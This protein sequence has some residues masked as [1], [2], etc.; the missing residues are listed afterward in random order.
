MKWLLAVLAVASSLH[1]AERLEYSQAAMGT[2]FR[3]SLYAEDKAKADRVVGQ[4]WKRV[5]ELEQMA[6]DYLPESELSRLC[7]SSEPM[8]VSADL[9]ALLTQ[10]QAFAQQTE[11]A[12]DI[13]TGHLTQLWRRAKRKSALPAPA[14]LDEALSL[15]GWQRLQLGPRVSLLPRTQLDL[16]GIA[17]GYA[18]DVALQLLKDAGFPCAVVAASGDLA[19]GTAPPGQKGW[20]VKL[21]TFETETSLTTLQLQHCGVST[22]GD[23]HQFVEIDGRRFSHI[24]DPATGLG[25]ERKV[26]CS[27]IAPTATESDALATA[28]CVMGSEKAASLLAKHFREVKARLVDEAGVHWINA[29]GW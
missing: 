12:F 2:V 29:A 8:D 16:G 9:R 11:G 20:E 4:A 1:A 21:R 17:K 19:I 22:S 18:A 26:A 25:L 27:V 6:S 3:I 13:T 5:A 14:R 24:I 7:R 28:C 23:M 10:G 15:T